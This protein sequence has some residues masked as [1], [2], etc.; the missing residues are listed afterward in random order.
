VIRDAGAPDQAR[1]VSTGRPSWW[2]MVVA[3]S[4]QRKLRFYGSPDLKRWTP[5]GEFGPAGAVGGVWECPDLF[6]LPVDGKAEKTRWVLIVNLNPGAIAGGSGTQYFVGDFD[7]SRFTTASSGSATAALWADYGK[8]FYA[9]NSFSDIPASDG[10]RIWLGWISNWQ[11][12]G[13]P[14]RRLFTKSII[15]RRLR[16]SR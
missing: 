5:L 11:N 1:V 10:R 3:L 12:R 6:E 14:S 7:G 8:D 4:P 16:K 15:A 13:Y 9:T 2:V